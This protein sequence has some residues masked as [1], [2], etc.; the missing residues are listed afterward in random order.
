MYPPYPTLIYTHRSELQ[1]KQSD[2]HRLGKETGLK[3]NIDGDRPE[4]WRGIRLV[5]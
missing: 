1:E 2:K 4:A 3:R 5:G